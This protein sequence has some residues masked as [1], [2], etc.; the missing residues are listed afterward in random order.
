MKRILTLALLFNCVV[1]GLFAQKKSKNTVESFLSI[2]LG[3]PMKLNTY[4]HF[5]IPLNIE[6]QKKKTK[7]GFG[8]SL[9]AQYDRYF[10][11]DC[12]TRIPVGTYLVER[13]LGGISSTIRPYCKTLQYLSLK[14][15]IFG[16][17]Y[18]LRKKRWNMFAKLGLAANIQIF[19]RKKGDY[20]E[21]EVN[22][23]TGRT[24]QVINS[25]SLHFERS[26]TFFEFR[27]IALLGGMGFNYFLNNRSA[28]RF[29]IQPEKNML[30]FQN[31]TNKGYLIFGLGGIS[32]KI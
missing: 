26:T 9:A 7:W 2:E 22:Q 23:V 15:S 20:Y 11:G 1:C 18:F 3:V 32:F 24:S 12:N 25:G 17:Y 27:N 30:L 4:D 21:V 6:F 14:P 19:Q 13:D 29:T 5:P 31:N 8:A 16:S 10:F 28:L